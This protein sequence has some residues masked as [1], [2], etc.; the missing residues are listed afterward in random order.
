MLDKSGIR[1]TF[2]NII[3]SR[4]ICFVGFA[5]FSMFFGYQSGFCNDLC[6]TIFL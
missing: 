2:F 6:P 5:W 3:C 4:C 1:F